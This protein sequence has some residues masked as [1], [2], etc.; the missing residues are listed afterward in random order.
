MM[1]QGMAIILS[2][3]LLL[4][5]GGPIRAQAPGNN[6]DTYPPPDEAAPQQE[7]EA[8]LAKEQISGTVESIHGQTA[9]I[10]TE[11]GDRVSVDLGPQS[12][13]RA[14]GYHLRTGM[15]IR[16]EGWNNP[17]NPG[18]LF[19]AGIWGPDFYI[20]LTDN[21]GFPVW[22]NPD[23]YWTGWYPTWVYFD[24]YFNHPPIYRAGHGPWWYF[25]PVHRR[26]D[27][28]RGYRYYDRP[29]GGGPRVEPGPHGNPP[30]PRG[31]NDHHQD[32]GDKRDGRRGR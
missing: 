9:I 11:H 10:R 22:V 17:D 19:A 27:A 7:E 26:H 29:H 6:S 31:G 20:E 12:V 18:L 15:P 1:R 21:T 25:G 23:E 14:H 3:F 2:L 4:A 5:F 8:P 24:F 28:Y 16:V 13:W 30:P 32:G